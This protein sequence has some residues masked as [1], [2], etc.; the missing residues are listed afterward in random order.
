MAEKPP[1]SGG[2]T[3]MT[4]VGGVNDRG[5]RLDSWKAIAAYLGRDVGTVR[6]WER[7][8]GLP[9]H[10]V[11]GGKGSSVFAHTAEVDQWLKSA[12]Q[13]PASTDDAVADPGESAPR[14]VWWF[15]AAAAAL[16]AMVAAIWIVRQPRIDPARLQVHLTDRGLTA[17]DGDGRQLWVHRL[18]D[19]YRHIASP[20]SETVRIVGGDDPAVFYITSQ[21]I[22]RTDNTGDGGELTSLDPAGTPRFTFRFFDTV[23]FGGT[24]FT[25]PWAIT[26]FSI[27]D[28]APRR[29]AVAAHHWVWSPSLIAILDDKGNRLGTYA[30]HGWIEQLQWI[31]RDRLVFGGFHESRNGGLVGLLDPADLDAQTPEEPGSRDY[32]VTCGKNQPLRLAVMPRSEVNLATQSR[33]NRAIVERMGDRIVVRTVEFPP[34]DGQGAADAIY[35]FTAS[36]E[37]VSASYSQRY[38]ETHDRLER[39]GTLDHGRATCPSK[40]GPP[41]IHLWARDSGWTVKTI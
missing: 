30:N 13:E 17:A 37:L 33:F 24:N 40:G 5:E 12:P 26:A 35:E 39:D 27:E 10:R 31:A 14:P 11:P 32:C 21:R 28:S 9:V 1:D 4:G 23:Q 29:L 15:V 25:A 22:R 20:V 7:T 2:H 6:R 3:E 41:A 8:R 16:V 19:E 36:L 38:W 18:D 34:L